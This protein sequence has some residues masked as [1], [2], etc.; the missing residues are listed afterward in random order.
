MD[1]AKS[2]ALHTLRDNLE[3]IVQH[4]ADVLDKGR[5]LGSITFDAGKQDFQ[6]TIELAKEFAGL[7]LELLFTDELQAL[8]APT[9]EAA[10]G[11]QQIRQFTL[12]EGADPA[13]RRNALLKT[14]KRNYVTLCKRLRPHQAFLELKR[15]NVQYIITES[16][17]LLQEIRTAFGSAEAY[18]TEMKKEIDSIVQTAREAVAKIGVGQFATNFEEMAETHK[19]SAG[20]WLWATAGFAV[21]TVAVVVL[22]LF[23]LPVSAEAT[24]T[25]AP[26]A[27]AVHRLVADVMS[28]ANAIQRI[29]TK[30]VIISLF[31][32]AVV[33]SARNYRAHRHLHVVNKHRQNALMTFETFVKGAEGDETKN[34]VLLE[35]T[36]CIFSPT[37]TGYLGKEEEHPSSRIIEILKTTSGPRT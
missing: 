16:A 13:G 30:L 31:Y 14:A 15:A 2:K 35:A 4:D 36:H 23:W 6:D 17:R 24:T 8:V 7:P 27:S 37:V 18:T 25:T 10:A 11:L 26:A 21:A 34:A 32:F 1:D 22:L 28:D 3:A 29:V 19:K 9:S 20:H 33:W 5:H 12:A